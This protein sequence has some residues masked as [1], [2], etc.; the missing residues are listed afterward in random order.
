MTLKS[1]ELPHQVILLN[2]KNLTPF[3]FMN[4]HTFM[5]RACNNLGILHNAI[6]HNKSYTLLISDSLFHALIYSFTSQLNH[7]YSE[8]LM[9]IIMKKTKIVCTLGPATDAPEI[10]E[11]LL[12]NGMNVARFNF[13][14]GTHDDHRTRINAIREA[15]KRVDIPVAIMLDTKGPEMRLGCFKNAKVNLKKGQ[16]FTLTTEDLLGDETIASINHQGLPQEIQKGNK[17]LLADGLI[18]LTVQAIE[19]NHIITLVENTGVISDRKRV[20]APG[21]SL[22]LPPI[23]EKDIEDILFGIA[24]DI[25]FIAASF[26]QRASDVQVIRK[27]LEAN[28]STI[29]IISKIENAEGVNN[30]EAIL[31]ASDGLMVARGDLGVEIPAEEVPL[32]QKTMI[33]LANQLGK[34]IITATQMLE[35]MISNPRPTRAEASDVANAILDGTDAIMLSGETASGQYPVEAV[36]TMTSIAKRTEQVIDCERGLIHTG[37]KRTNTTDAISHATVQIAVELNIKGI[38]IAT[39]SG[40]TAQMVSRYKPQPLILAVTPHDKTIRR[41][42][43]IWGVIALKGKPTNNTDTMTKTAIQCCMDKGYIMMGDLV[44]VTAGI[45]IG[46]KGSTNMIQVHVAGNSLGS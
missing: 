4:I 37:F 1:C 7:Q 2:T 20:A 36:K 43:L 31:E 23:S 39:E 32:I 28:N 6:A 15:S 22:G 41:L 29:Q 16:C 38:I 30:L 45:P 42:Q 25:D 21:V 19:N 18:E 13:S 33:K 27:L 10:L 24:Q 3:S 40:F 34:P 11:Q 44:E 8:Y 17:I 46:T 14:H 35:S 9:E 5:K 26:I 12:I